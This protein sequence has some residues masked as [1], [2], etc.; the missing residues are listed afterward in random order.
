MSDRLVELEELLPE[1]GP[2][3]DRRRIGENL[4]RVVDKLQDADRTIARFQAIRDI[5]TEIEF[6]S[7]P[8]QADTL[9]RLIEDAKGLAKDLEGA[10][11]A[12]DMAVVQATYGDFNSSLANTDKSL[13]THWRRVAQRDFRPL[14]A[15]GELLENIEI[16]V[17]LGQ[18]LRQCG[19]EAIDIRDSV[20]AERLSAEIRRVRE[21]RAAL[22]KE[23][24]SIT[25]DPDV[26]SFL[27]A[28]A[29]RTAT[30]SMITDGIYSW[31]DENGALD[32]FAITPR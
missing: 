4:G 11:T 1:I 24:T 10:R 15:I 18:R 13:R 5:A 30:L 20:P 31:L 26:D 17:D 3:L 22:E 2:A 29:D 7:D 14:V 32:R 25:K 9:N 6:D 8:T 12:E 19:Q 28:L 21:I 27:N 16:A 23:R